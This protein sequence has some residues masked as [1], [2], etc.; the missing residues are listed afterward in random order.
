MPPRNKLGLGWM[1]IY[2]V[3]I[4]SIAGLFFV[5]DQWLP[6]LGVVALLVI[7]VLR[8]RRTEYQEATTYLDVCRYCKQ[9]LTES[10]RECP[11]C[12]RT[13]PKE[14]RME[15]RKKADLR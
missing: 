5:S 10:D 15:I 4:L 1:I 6:R 11:K 7:T 13:V 14:Q 2:G 9:G 8:I 3:L 12:D